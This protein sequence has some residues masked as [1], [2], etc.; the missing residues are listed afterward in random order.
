MSDSY[1]HNEKDR[2]WVFEVKIQDGDIISEDVL[3]CQ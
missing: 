2:R 1:I 3:V